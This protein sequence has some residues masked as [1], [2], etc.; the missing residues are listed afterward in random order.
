MHIFIYVRLFIY[1]C[2]S[3]CKYIRMYINIYPSLIDLEYLELNA[4]NMYF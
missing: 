4:R 3:L 2:P 1:V